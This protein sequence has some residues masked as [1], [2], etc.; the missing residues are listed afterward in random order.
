VKFTDEGLQM[1]ERLLDQL[2]VQRPHGT[3]AVR[4]ADDP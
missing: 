3:G 4:Q 2:F 1:S